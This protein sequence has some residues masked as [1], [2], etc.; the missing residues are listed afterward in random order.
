MCYLAILTKTEFLIR[1]LYLSSLLWQENKVDFRLELL[2]PIA[3][4]LEKTNRRYEVI[5]LQ[6]EMCTDFQGGSH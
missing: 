3:L 1:F 4:H 2:N 6:H 5:W